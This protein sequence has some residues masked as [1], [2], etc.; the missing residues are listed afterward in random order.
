MFPFPSGLKAVMFPYLAGCPPRARFKALNCCSV[1]PSCTTDLMLLMEHL[2]SNV[3]SE[4]VR[5]CIS[6]VVA[7]TAPA[8]ALHEPASVTS[9]M[10][11]SARIVLISLADMD[12]QG[13]KLSVT[14]ITATDGCHIHR[15]ASLHAV[16]AAP[17][18]TMRHSHISRSVAGSYRVCI[19]FSMLQ[20]VL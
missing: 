19:L 12:G 14:V 18:D 17:P 4:Q 6:K 10:L 11:D 9:A 15:V 2:S 5:H 16:A 13:C 8:V 20:V 3:T 7:K 1:S